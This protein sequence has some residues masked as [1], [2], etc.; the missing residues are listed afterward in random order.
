MRGSDQETATVKARRYGGAEK[1]LFDKKF[2]GSPVEIGT[3][4][5]HYKDFL[6]KDETVKMEFKGLRD[7]LVFTQRRLMVIDP[8]GLRGQKVAIMVGSLALQRSWCTAL[9]GSAPRQ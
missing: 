2:I 1:T 8:H 4:A 5:D 7:A 3:S 9:R 6:M